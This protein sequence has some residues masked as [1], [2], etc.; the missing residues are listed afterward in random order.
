[1]TDRPGK[2]SFSLR[3]PSADY[4]ESEGVDRQQNTTNA[5]RYAG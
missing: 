2:R 4:D 5:I 1:M 3:R